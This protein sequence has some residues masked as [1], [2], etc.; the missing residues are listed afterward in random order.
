MSD[1]DEIAELKKRVAYLENLVWRISMTAHHSAHRLREI[2][3]WGELLAELK[4]EGFGTE[5]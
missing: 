5:K 1:R 3:K 2:N 4:D